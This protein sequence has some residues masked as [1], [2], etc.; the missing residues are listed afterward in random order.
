MLQNLCF[1]PYVKAEIA[2]SDNILR[3]RSELNDNIIPLTS[4]GRMNGFNLNLAGYVK[5]KITFSCL[6]VLVQQINSRC[7]GLFDKKIP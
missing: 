1:N 7:N 5:L 3:I 2:A 4:P 6:Q